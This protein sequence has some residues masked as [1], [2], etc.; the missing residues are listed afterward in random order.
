MSDVLWKEGLV[1]AETFL[2]NSNTGNETGFSALAN[3]GAVSSSVSGASGVFAPSVWGRAPYGLIIFN[4]GGAFTP[5]VNGALLGWFRRSLDGGTT[6]ESL[7]TTP[8]TTVPALERA[9][10]FVIPLSNVAHASGNKVLAAWPVEIPPVPFMVTVQ[11][12]SGVTLPT[13]TTNWIK[14]ASAAKRIE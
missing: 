7:I 6:F 9:P 10:D 13:S 14:M 3:G 1:T 11:S 2:I 8:S 4:A 12:R 5:A